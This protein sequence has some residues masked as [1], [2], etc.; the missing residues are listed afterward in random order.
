MQNTSDKL[1]PFLEHLAELRSRLLKILIGLAISICISYSSA[2]EIFNLLTR[3]LQDGFKDVQLI[4]TGPAEAFMCKLTVSIAAGLVLSV[5]WIFFQIWQFVAPG[6]LP[7]ERRYALP[8]VAISSFFFLLGL[9]FCYRVV[10]PFGFEFFSA[11]FAS[12]E[13]KPTIRVGE[14]LSFV[15]RL[16]VVFGLIFELPVLCYFLAR[17]KILTHSWLL[18]KFRY[19]IVGI[20]IVAGILTPPDI[21]TQLL[22]A[23]PLLVI[24]LLCI[25]IVFAVNRDRNKTSEDSLPNSP[26]HLRPP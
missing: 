25:G 4:G 7:G 15:S 23:G 14:Y 20:F 5:P 18:S 24:Y 19:F 11:E 2:S 12:V 10:L 9:A 1:L 21:V 13:M 8:F 6:L 16:C 17:F 22:L 3:P 26:T